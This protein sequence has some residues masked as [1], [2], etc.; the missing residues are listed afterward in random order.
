M[1]E[2]FLN[3][4]RSTLWKPSPRTMLRP[5]FPNVPGR[6]D[7]ERRGVECQTGRDVLVR[8]ANYVRPVESLVA[9]RVEGADERRER[10]P[11]LKREDRVGL[12]AARKLISDRGSEA[13][14]YIEARYAALQREIAG[15]EDMLGRIGGP[16]VARVIDGFGKRVRSEQAEAVRKSPLDS[17]LPAVISGRRGIA[18]QSNGIKAGQGRRVLR[19]GV[20]SCPAAIA[21]C[22]RSR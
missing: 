2:K 18:A 5:A 22:M 21:C 8:I 9:I 6:G 20:V 7:A 10:L 14:R 12:P 13:V 4:E 3:T 16:E 1:K 19:I 17:D 11:R 15:V